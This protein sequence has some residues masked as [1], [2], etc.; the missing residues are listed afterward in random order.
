M[1]IDRARP[2]YD[3]FHEITQLT[4][5]QE[6]DLQEQQARLREMREKIA[7]QKLETQVRRPKKSGAA[8]SRLTF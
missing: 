2:D 1:F 5:E 3:S 4:V 8:V 7:R 6:Q